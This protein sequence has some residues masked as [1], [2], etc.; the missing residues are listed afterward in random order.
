MDWNRIRL[1]FPS[2]LARINYGTALLRG[3][4]SI[5]HLAG[6]EDVIFDDAEGASALAV[7]ENKSQKT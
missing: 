6:D 2:Y 7:F 5:R 3:E 1:L 4:N